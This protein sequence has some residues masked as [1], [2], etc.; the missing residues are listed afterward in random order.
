MPDGPAA[1]GPPLPGPAAPGPAAAAPSTDA[2]V[3]A[4]TAGQLR[5]AASRYATGVAVVT[6]VVDGVDHAM[7]ANSFTT[8]SLDPLL[9][10]VCVE[11]DSRFHE[12]VLAA[13]VWS[14]SFLAEGDEQLARWFATRGR[15]LTRQFDGVPTRR[16][17]NGCLLLA[18]ALAGLELR[19]DQVVPAGDHDIVVGA[20]TAVHEPREAPDGTPLG[21][22]VY[23]AS[24]FR[25][26]T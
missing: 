6:T 24:R 16:G 23:F 10:L 1:P 25:R 15:P 20:V 19:T 11:R 12:A 26:L 7:T 2:P 17:A 18:D 13:G 9:A 5:R 4:P 8:V 14:V 3:A 21:P 22:T